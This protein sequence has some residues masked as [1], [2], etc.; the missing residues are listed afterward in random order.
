MP[1]FFV[2]KS[3]VKDGKTVVICGE[4]AKHISLSL[5]S[6]PGE[7]FV[8]CD[9]EGVEYNCVVSEITKNE[10]LLKVLSQ[11]A[12]KTEPSVSVTLYQALV[13]SD[14][15]ESVV[16]K[17]VELGVSRIVPV[18]MQRCVSRPD[19]ASLGKKLER[20]RKIAREAAMQS[21]R[22]RQCASYGCYHRPHRRNACQGA[23]RG[24]R[25]GYQRHLLFLAEN[26]LPSGYSRTCY[27]LWQLIM[28]LRINFYSKMLVVFI[29]H[30]NLQKIL[31]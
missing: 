30:K 27:T 16:Q 4:D 26:D 19:D 28:Q 13:K 31:I 11:Q 29:S 5:R 6:K 3:A 1:R 20:W 22:H 9:G 15:F 25:S 2:E 12:S 8:V 18:V 24:S 10:V 17:S 21:S 23:D 7:S 14:K